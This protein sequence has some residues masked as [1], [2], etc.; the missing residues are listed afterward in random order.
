[1]TETGV[2]PAKEGNGRGRIED[3][4]QREKA[5]MKRAKIHKV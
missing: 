2:C 5:K 3:K 1:M 4:K